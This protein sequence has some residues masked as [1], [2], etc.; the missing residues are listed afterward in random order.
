MTAGEV[1]PQ[2]LD[3]V[4][5]QH[6]P[7]ANAGGAQLGDRAGLAL[8]DPRD[9][10]APADPRIAERR[11]TTPDKLRRQLRG[12]LDTIASKALKKNPAERYASDSALKEDLRRCLQLPDRP[13]GQRAVN[14]I[15]CTDEGP[16]GVLVDHVGDV[17]NV[18]DHQFEPTPRTVLG[19]G[20]E[21]IAGVYKLKNQLLLVVDKVAL[22]SAACGQP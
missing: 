20:G 22:L 9:A 15:L 17:L 8:G 13:A 21:L 18:D 5:H 1:L 19:R 10:I 16:V 3:V 6:P 4:H 14:V 2:R 12:D 11:A 7:H